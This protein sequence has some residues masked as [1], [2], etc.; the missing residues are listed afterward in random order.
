MR[1]I[2]RPGTACASH[3]LLNTGRCAIGIISIQKYRI[4][5]VDWLSL[6]TGR[7]TGEV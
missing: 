1:L 6:L 4:E 2:G 5:E 3:G 7:N